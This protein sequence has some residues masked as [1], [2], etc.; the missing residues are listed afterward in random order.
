MKSK[1][2][3]KRLT[4]P[5]DEDVQKRFKLATEADCVP[6]R[7]MADIGRMLMVAYCDLIEK[8]P[9]I[10]FATLKLCEKDEVNR[11]SRPTIPPVTPG[12]GH[13]LSRRIKESTR[14]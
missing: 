10:K 7:N 8:N 2:K 1:P 11:P 6:G 13:S 3:N 9:G 4:I 12:A 14:R 5:I